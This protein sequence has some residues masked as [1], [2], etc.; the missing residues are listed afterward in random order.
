M[1]RQLDRWGRVG[2]VLALTAALAG[3]SQLQD[4]GVAVCGSVGAGEP[5]VIGVPFVT[6]DYP[7]EVSG[8]ELVDAEGLDLL[9]ARV[10]LN[11]TR[12]GVVEYPVEIEGW[13]DG[14][15]AVGADL[16][17]RT[18]VTLA[19]VLER[20]AEVGTADGVEVA[21]S[22]LVGPGMRTTVTL[23]MTLRDRCA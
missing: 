7:V 4:T 21:Y 12:V 8:L 5:M 23:E 20:T 13:V 10:D 6:G 1:V 2:A 19:L 18:D 3:C 14:G 17:A 22:S 16:P 15:P 11:T 9:D